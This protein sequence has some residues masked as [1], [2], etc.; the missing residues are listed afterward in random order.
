MSKYEG[1][2][3]FVPQGFDVPAKRFAW[4]G[5]V[6]R[7]EAGWHYSTR[8]LKNGH[9][10]PH[11]KLHLNTEDESAPFYELAEKHHKS[12]LEKHGTGNVV[13]MKGN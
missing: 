7:L 4:L 12:W 1:P 11:Q 6:Q 10:V 9:E 2:V 8:F 5:R 3:C 13:S